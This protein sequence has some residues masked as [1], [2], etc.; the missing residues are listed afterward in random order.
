MY[1]RVYFNSAAVHETHMQSKSQEAPVLFS[2]S[3]NQVSKSEV[4]S[5]C[6]FICKETVFARATPKNPPNLEEE[7]SIY[8]P[9]A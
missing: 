4:A 1:I 5:M 6:V 2:V 9:H 8:L 7:L 3:E